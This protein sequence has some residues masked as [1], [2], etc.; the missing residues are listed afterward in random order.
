MKNPTRWGPT[1]A[2]GIVLIG[3]IAALLLL[4]P[5]AILPALQL[6]RQL[7]ILTG[8][9]TAIG[10]LLI[11][12]YLLNWAW[13]GFG[14]QM[15]PKIENHEYHRGKTL[16][17]WMQ[18]LIVPSVLATAAFL[19]NTWNAEIQREI[20]DDNQREA[21]LQA[22]FDKMSELLVNKGADDNNTS[23]GIQT[24]A[25]TR[26]LT[27][28]RRLDGDRQRILLQ[29]LRDSELFS[30]IRGPID[31]NGADLRNVALRGADLHEADLSEGNLGLADLSGAS[32]NG[33]SLGGANMQ[34]ANLSNADL[35][36]SNLG[37]TDLCDANLTLADLSDSNISVSNLSGANFYSANLSGANLSNSNLGGATLDD[38]NLNLSDLSG[39]N[40]LN[41]SVQNANLWKA[42][43]SGANLSEANLTGAD[44]RDANLSGVRISAE[45]LASVK[46][47]QGTTMPDRSRHN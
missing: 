37:G 22:Y 9:V 35:T 26:T 45:Q 29:F 2:L 41:A 15:H 8:L 31:L 11:G 19:F 25:R 36:D 10:I 44:L 17:D 43:L 33:A 20:A 5:I 34:G 14:P 24:V 47:L 1:I 28:L 42:D 39:A 7:W 38:A 3:I 12:G 18:L 13:T 32:L 30:T 6:P 27:L 16:W 4:R 23:A 40:L 21:A 46:S